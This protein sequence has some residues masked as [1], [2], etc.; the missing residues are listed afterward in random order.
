MTQPSQQ[1]IE[2]VKERKLPWIYYDESTGRLTLVIDN[3][4]LSM[5]RSCAAHFMLVA[6][7]GWHRK[8]ISQDV[9]REWALDFGILFHKMMELYYRDFQKPDFD[10][11]DF[12]IKAAAE[13]WYSMKMDV[14][15][16][17]KECQAMGGYPGFAGMMIQYATQFKAENERLRVLATEVPFGRNKEVPIFSQFHRATSKDSGEVIWCEAD[18][19]LAGRLDIIAD[20]GFHILPLD[21]KTM[22][23]F[24][25]DPLS[26]FVVD[27]GPTGYVFALNAI[28][29]QIMPD[30][31]ER[32]K[33]ECNQIQMNLISKAIPKEGSRFKRFPL[34]KTSDQLE[35]YRLR[36]IQTC[37]HLLSDLKLV[38]RGLGVPRDTSKCSN[39]YFRDCPFLDVHRQASRDAEQATLN[40]GFIQL[41]I[42]NTEEVAKATED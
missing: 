33:R 26:R 27:D 25:G 31:V 14:H 2:W 13:E 16:N 41:P 29:P 4:L 40:N 8:S 36:V 15:L 22:G 21:H 19:Y 37:N 24:R 30:S 9:Q 38:A 1:L 20:D 18:I 7:D 34:Y 39:W 35:S 12:A 5:Y 10:L 3:Y 11:K 32:L 17:H 42:W 6:V 28:L 23:S